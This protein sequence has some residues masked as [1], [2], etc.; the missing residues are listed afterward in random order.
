[1]HTIRVKP[2]EGNMNDGAYSR[3]SERA[4]GSSHSHVSEQTTGS[5]RAYAAFYD[6]D[7]S[8]VTKSSYAR[9]KGAMAQ[10]LPRQVKTSAFDY[11][12]QRATVNSREER[13][14]NPGLAAAGSNIAQVNTDSRSFQKAQKQFYLLPSQSST[15]S[16]RPVSHQSN[17]SQKDHLQEIRGEELQFDKDQ[18]AFY[19]G[20]TPKPEQ[21]QNRQFENY[22]Q[23][24]EE[25]PKQRKI[26]SSDSYRDAQRRF[27]GVES[28]VS[29]L[30]LVLIVMKLFNND[31]IMKLIHIL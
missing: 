21:M 18:N 20:Y 10:A 19:A 11:G 5:K 6:L 22:K 2:I 30:F 15:H 8:Q 31:L 3:T 28:R 26:E 1:M 13:L 27:F 29:Y 14:R 12:Q 9:T 16:N 7:P 17:L 23:N 25:K 4:L 24:A